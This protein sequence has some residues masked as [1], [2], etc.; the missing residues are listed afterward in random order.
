MLGCFSWDHCKRAQK[1]AWIQLSRSI[2]TPFGNWLPS[3]FGIRPFSFAS[4]PF[5]CFAFV[6]CVQEQVG[7]PAL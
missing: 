2:Y 4:Q 5:D 7:V 3:P 6:V 1:N